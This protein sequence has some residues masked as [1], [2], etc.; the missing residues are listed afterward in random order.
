MTDRPEYF[1]KY[2]TINFERSDDGVLVVRLHSDDGP[3]LYGGTHHGEWGPAFTD[4]GA[5]RG[6]RVV[7][8]TGTGDVFINEHGAWG[9]PIE[10]PSHWDVP[11]WGQKTL[12]NRLL[13]IEAPIIGAVNGPATIHAELAVL[14]DIVLCA[15][16]SVFAD[17][18]HFAVGETPADGV[19]VVWQELIG[20]NRGRYFLLTGQNIDAWEALRLGVVNEVMPLDALMPRALELAHQMATYSDLTLRYTRTVLIDRWKQLFAGGNAIG[21]GMALEA[22]SFLDRGWVVWDKSNEGKENY[23]TL[24]RLHAKP[25]TPPP[26]K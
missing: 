22:L 10:T 12:M 23:R 25:S 26:G 24:R 9:Q 3:V 15:D 2:E 19:Q 21:H 5:D 8:L 14:S 1:D 7:V 17:E 20:T 16:H 18:G 11:G 6:N 13:E 4:I